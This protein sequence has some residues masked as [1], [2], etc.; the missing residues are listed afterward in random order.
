MRI[1]FL[2]PLAWLAACDSGKQ[3]AVRVANGDARLGKQLLAQYQCGTCHQIAGVPAARGQLAPPLDSFGQRSYIAGS[4]PNTPEMLAR[5]LVNP[6]A[7][8]PGT[9]MPAMGVSE[10]DARHMAAYLYS[11][12]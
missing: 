4:V 12:P 7:L 11:L 10:E 6:P 1:L 9:T 3:E 5:W 8:K 2:L